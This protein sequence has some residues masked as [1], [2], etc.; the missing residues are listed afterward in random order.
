M[1]L[2]RSY[3]Y[4][5]IDFLFEEIDS[6]TQTP[7]GTVAHGTVVTYNCQAS[8][9]EVT[10]YINGR[11][12]HTSFDGYNISIDEIGSSNNYNLTLSTVA[13]Y[14]K[15][16]TRVTCYAEGILSLIE[17]R[18]LEIRVAGEEK[19]LY[20]SAGAARLQEFV[21]AWGGGGG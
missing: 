3:S 17:R 11:R 8:G 15:N 12:R 6:F 2:A 16:N 1:I 18:V 7:N 19:V 14:E 20:T 21:V 5:A 9:F 4:Y 13:L 10:W